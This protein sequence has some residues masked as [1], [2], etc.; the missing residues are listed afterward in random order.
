VAAA[1]TETKKEYA[2]GSG[3]GNTTNRRVVVNDRE[4]EHNA[5]R[6]KKARNDKQAVPTSASQ[7][8]H[9]RKKG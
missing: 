2:G 5:V 3:Q 4:G 1:W 6:G 7:S 8:K 9:G